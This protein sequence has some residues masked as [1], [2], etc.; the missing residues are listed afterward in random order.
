MKRN[1]RISIWFNSIVYD[2]K[3]L[4]I[5]EDINKWKLRFLLWNCELLSSIKDYSYRIYTFKNSLSKA[6]EELLNN[7]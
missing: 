4:D 5:K 3:E 1:K 2:I 7:I 6:W